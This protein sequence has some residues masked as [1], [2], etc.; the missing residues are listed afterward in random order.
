ML[1]S[2]SVCS[3]VSVLASMSVCSFVV[4]SVSVSPSRF[5]TKSAPGR[6]VSYLRAD[7]NIV[8]DE[9]L[10]GIIKPINKNKADPTKNK[11]DPTKPE[12][13]RPITLLSCLGKL[14]TSILST[15]LEAY[16]N[17][18]N[19]I[20][21]SQTGFRKG[22]STLDHVLTLQFLSETLMKQKKKLFC[23]FIDF[24]Q[25]FDTIWRSGLW[26]KM[27]KMV[28]LENVLFILKICI[29][30]LNLLLVWMVS[31]LIL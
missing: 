12:N 28:S 10:V 29:R 13:Y 20:S 15:R 26:Y 5:D 25:A 27:S 3:F 9:W 1:A 16:A 24:K 30:V 23:A 2:M 4:V 21:E 18:I 11:G 8:P 6:W 19:I 22:Y 14:F 17:E 31:H 7:S